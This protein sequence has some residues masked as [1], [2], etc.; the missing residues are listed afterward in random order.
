MSEEKREQL[1]KLGFGPNKINLY[2]NPDICP[3]Y[4]NPQK[5]NHHMICWKLLRFPLNLDNF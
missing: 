2:D 5:Y 4:D 3:D 1:V